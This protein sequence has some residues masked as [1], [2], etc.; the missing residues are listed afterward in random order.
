[1]RW[2]GD[3]PADDEVSSPGAG[4]DVSVWLESHARI[5]AVGTGSGPEGGSPTTD[6][7]RSGGSEA[8]KAG[9]QSSAAPRIHPRRARARQSFIMKII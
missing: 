1:V 3:P 9:G 7:Q 6:C 8:E 4:G 5:F 2:R